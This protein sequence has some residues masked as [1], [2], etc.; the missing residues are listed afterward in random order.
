MKELVIIGAGAA[1]FAALIR[2][3]ELG[4]K[5]T[6][7]NYGLP[8]GGTC[9]NVGCIPS[10][11]LLRIGEEYKLVRKVIGENIYPDLFSVITDKDNLVR[12]LR[13]E[14]YED[15]ISK[16]D[17]EYIEGKAY[18]I[19]PNA[20]KVNGKIIE[21]KKFIIATGSSP[22]VPE[23]PGLREAGFWTSNEALNPD[24]KISSLI[25]IGGRALALEFAQIYARLGV[26]VAVLQRSPLLIPDWEPEISLF[27]EEILREDGVHVFTN[28]RVIEVKRN[29]SRKI[30]KT[31][32]G[33]IEGEEILVATGRKPNTNI[34][35]NN[36]GV[37]LNEKGGIKVNEELRTTNPNIFAAGDVIGLK[38]LESLA[39]KQGSIAV[40]NA[41]RNSG[42]KIDFLSIPQAIF[43]QP[44]LAKV[45]LTVLEAKRLFN[46]DYR[47]V[48]MKDIPKARVIKSKGLIKM[49][50]ES[51]SK[52]ILGVHVAGEYAAEVI[53]EASLA[54][55]LR[56][57]IYD[58]IDTIHVFPTISESI[59]IAAMAFERD[60]SKISCCVD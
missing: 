1:G 54:I 26:E 57:T 46:I 9:V 22:I 48:K 49:V 50:I 42:R 45:G 37:E 60:V 5:P 29:G 19:S 59:K 33:E 38:M 28:V 56:A 30:I 25:I 3:N 13:K 55:R 39:G 51:T 17:V 21:G 44:N 7:I 35:L 2:A 24:R 20:V 14:K 23:I 52:R 41:I 34:G 15:V 31:N 6:V 58:I 10:K 43:I 16:Y 12:E 40:D 53:N 32:L 18:F 11:R 8:L 27:A 4:I 47:L 36:A